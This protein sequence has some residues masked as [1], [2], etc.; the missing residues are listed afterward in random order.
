MDGL[1]HLCI[2]L[3]YVICIVLRQQ[4]EG[5]WEQEIVQKSGYGYVMQ[6]FVLEKASRQAGFRVCRLDDDTTLATPSTPS[7][8]L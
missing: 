6:G 1:G 5:V 3:T 2:I 8:D 4:D 7:P